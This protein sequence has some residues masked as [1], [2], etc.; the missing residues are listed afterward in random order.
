M[1]STL[2]ARL[3][4][5]AVA[6]AVAVSLVGLER[7]QEGCQD[8]VERAYLASQA[9]A[10]ELRGHVDEVVRECRGAEPLNRIAVGLRIERPGVAAR[11]ARIASRR[12]PDSYV[13]WGVL[14][15]AAAPAEAAAARRRAGELNPLS[16]G[17]SP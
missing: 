10:A 8:A 11:L 2:I 14:A 13:A 1:R 16:V 17:A 9:P 15:V 4:L 3:L 12:E 6:I 5:A 7:D